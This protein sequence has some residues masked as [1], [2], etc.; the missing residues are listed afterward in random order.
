MADTRID[1]ARGG[2]LAPVSSAMVALHKEQFGRGPRRARSNFAGADALVCVLEDALLP[3]ELT[4]VKMGDQQRVRESRMSLQV[5]TARRV[6]R[7]RRGHRRTQG[8]RLLERDRPRRRL[9]LGGLHLRAGSL[10]RRA[11]PTTALKRRLARYVLVSRRSRSPAAGRARANPAVFRPG[12]AIVPP[13]R[14]KAEHE[15][16]WNAPSAEVAE[17]VRQSRRA[18]HDGRSSSSGT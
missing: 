9:R 16:R 11:R 14:T 8:P 3:A 18:R 12:S 6:H 15:Q 10:E 4:M 1:D 17:L 2:V 5:A 13:S 7:R